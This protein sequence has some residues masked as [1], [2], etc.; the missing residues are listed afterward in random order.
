MI[1]KQSNIIIAH[2]STWWP[3][4]GCLGVA[5]MLLVRICLRRTIS[6]QVTSCLENLEDLSWAYVYFQKHQLIILALKINTEGESVKWYFIQRFYKTIQ[7]YM[8]LST[9]AEN[10]SCSFLFKLFVMSYPS[11]LCFVFVLSGSS[12]NL[13]WSRRYRTSRDVTWMTG[14]PICLVHVS[15]ISRTLNRLS[16]A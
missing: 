2:C 7:K 13:F 8:K 1:L 11:G 5:L 16:A 3:L 4:C 9:S 12:R 14:Y 6:I 10:N 15:I